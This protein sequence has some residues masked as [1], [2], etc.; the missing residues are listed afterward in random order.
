MFARRMASGVIDILVIFMLMV[1]VFM[2]I[3]VAG[4]MVYGSLQ[5]MAFLWEKVAVFMVTL[6]LACAF[7]I[8]GLISF[9][10]SPLQGASAS[11]HHLFALMDSTMLLIMAVGLMVKLCYFGFMLSSS[12]SATVGMRCLDCVAQTEKA[13]NKTER[14][15]FGRA[16][17]WFFAHMVSILSL[18]IGYLW[19][20]WDGKGQMLHD[21]IAGLVIKKGRCP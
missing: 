9:E 10:S 11:L 13:K 7:F 12:R 20:V 17:I 3:N 21:K 5:E 16:V 14:L 15:S 8:F 19:M 4:V 18:G 6:Y 1:A 2:L